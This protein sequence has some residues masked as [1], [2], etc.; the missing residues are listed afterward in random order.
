MKNSAVVIGSMV[1]F[2]ILISR[3]TVKGPV[4]FLPCYINYFL[5]PKETSTIKRIWLVFSTVFST[6]YT[7]GLKLMWIGCQDFWSTRFYTSSSTKYSNFSVSWDPRKLTRLKKCKYSDN[8][9]SQ[10]EFIWTWLGQEWDRKLTETIT[11][12][13]QLHGLSPNIYLWCDARIIKT[14]MSRNTDGTYFGPNSNISVTILLPLLAMPFQTLVY[15]VRI[16]SSHTYRESVVQQHLSSWGITKLSWIFLVSKNWNS[17]FCFSRTK[18]MFQ[19]V[20]VAHQ[21]RKVRHALSYYAF[22]DLCAESRSCAIKDDFPF[23]PLG[24]CH[25]CR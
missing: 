12:S 25:I 1:L 8:R 17:F 2:W 24:S 4:E 20:T 21:Q 3:E 19:I 16:K 9:T 14:E 18:E 7:A 10:T 22:R 23:I 15:V 11:N 13:R 5:T 6:Y